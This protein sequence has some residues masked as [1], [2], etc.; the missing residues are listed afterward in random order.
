MRGLEERIKELEAA[1]EDLERIAKAKASEKS[2]EVVKNLAAKNALTNVARHLNVALRQEKMGAIPM[3]AK[4]MF[5]A[6]V[7]KHSTLGTTRGI[8]SE[9][10]YYQKSDSDIRGGQRFM[11]RFAKTFVGT[12]TTTRKIRPSFS[13]SGADDVNEGDPKPQ[14][15]YAFTQNDYAFSKLAVTDTITQE[16]ILADAGEKAANFIVDALVEHVKDALNQ[17]LIN[18]LA[19]F[20]TPFNPSLFAGLLNIPSGTAR[21]HDLISAAQHQFEQLFA[22]HFL[23]IKFGDILLVPQNI[24]WG[25]VQDRKGNGSNLYYDLGAIGELTLSSIWKDYSGSKMILTHTEGLVIELV[26]DV[27]LYYN[28]IAD[29]ADERNLYRVTVEVYYRFVPAKLPLPAI[30]IANPISDLQAIAP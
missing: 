25:I 18:Y 5:A 19:A 22:D 7:F 2:E 28:R 6:S 11:D 30:V 24:H 3:S 29:A 14:R 12:N 8:T 21:W 10:D 16:I 27:Q 26:D 13:G 20:G 4:S 23:D 1:A 17:K 15:Q 9:F